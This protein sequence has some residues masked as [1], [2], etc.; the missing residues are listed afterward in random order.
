M[1][2]DSSSKGKVREKTEYM[3]TS[4]PKACSLG[5]DLRAKATKRNRAPWRSGRF[6]SWGRTSLND[7]M[8]PENKEALKKDRA[9]QKDAG[10]PKGVLQ[11]PNLGQ[12]EPIIVVLD[13]NP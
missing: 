1:S 4:H 5:Q 12:F 2:G 8:V 10:Q 11:W 6:Q 3:R 13:Y 7:L 9:S